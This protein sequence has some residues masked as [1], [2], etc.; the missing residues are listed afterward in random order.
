MSRILKLSAQRISASLAM[1]AIAIVALAQGT[2]ELGRYR[3]TSSA[4]SG[5]LQYS[6]ASTGGLGSY[7]FV[8]AVGGVAFSEVASP[9][10]TLRG[11]AFYLLGA[12]PAAEFELNE[13]R[14]DEAVSAWPHYSKVVNSP[15]P[16]R[17]LQ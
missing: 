10:S 2:W 16:V 12:I 3:F 11:L 17:L 13:C 1:L 9:D 6:M 8:P 7:G 4:P 5:P 14:K 15:A